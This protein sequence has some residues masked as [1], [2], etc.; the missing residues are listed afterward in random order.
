MGET[1]EHTGALAGHVIASR[2]DPLLRG[3]CFG[4]SP[5]EDVQNTIVF[6]H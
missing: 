1:L 4:R 6:M 2:Q 5:H 3:S